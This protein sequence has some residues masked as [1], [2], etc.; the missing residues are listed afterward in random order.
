MFYIS[1]TIQESSPIYNEMLRDI[2][3]EANTRNEAGNVTG[4]L[5]RVYDRFI[6][7]LE[8]DKKK[9]NEIYSSI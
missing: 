9:V 2:L 8:G 3:N 1:C 6:Q 7:L 5:V 4:L